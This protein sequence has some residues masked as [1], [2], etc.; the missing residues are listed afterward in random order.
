MPTQERKS[1]KSRKSRGKTT[2]IRAKRK[3]KR[4]TQQRRV[5]LDR[6]TLAELQIMARSRGI[7]FGGLTRTQ[8]L[9]KINTYL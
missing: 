4:E 5:P 1:R 6:K 3:A 2:T 8:L 9:E 7:P